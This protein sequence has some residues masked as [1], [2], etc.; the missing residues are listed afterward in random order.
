MTPIL[1]GKKK[2]PVHDGMSALTLVESCLDTHELLGYVLEAC[3]LAEEHWVL[4]NAASLLKCSVSEI[5]R[6]GAAPALIP[7]NSFWREESSKT[8]AQGREK[9]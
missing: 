8:E 9:S 5:I 4:G 3:D 1:G 6:G 7:L 2:G